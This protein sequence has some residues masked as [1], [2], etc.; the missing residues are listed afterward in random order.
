MVFQVRTSRKR[1]CSITDSLRHENA[2]VYCVDTFFKTFPDL[3]LI[4]EVMPLK[5]GK[6]K[7]VKC[8]VLLSNSSPS[9]TPARA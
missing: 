5:F 9:V 6:E 2:Y 8:S 1:S 4:F 3:L 7:Q